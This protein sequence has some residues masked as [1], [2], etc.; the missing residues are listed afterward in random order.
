MTLDNTP[1]TNAPATAIN[2]THRTFVINAQMLQ[3]KS[4]LKEAARSILVFV[5][6]FTITFLVY[7]LA[8]V[9]FINAGENPNR[10]WLPTFLIYGS[11]NFFLNTSLRYIHAS[12][13]PK[14]KKI[15]NGVVVNSSIVNSSTSSSSS[16]SINKSDESEE[17]TGDFQSRD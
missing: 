17:E 2:K 9:A 3:N 4:N 14:L 11:L 5:R 10:F 12:L 16:S 13:R 6:G 7:V 15:R 1:S 8:L